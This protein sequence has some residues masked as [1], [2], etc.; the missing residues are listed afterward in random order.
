MIDVICDVVHEI[1]EVHE[2]AFEIGFDCGD[3]LQGGSAVEFVHYFD[4]LKGRQ[5]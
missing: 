5:R 4:K 3:V 1:F 2:R